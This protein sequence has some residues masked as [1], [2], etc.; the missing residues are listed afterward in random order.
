MRLHD[1]LYDIIDESCSVPQIQNVFA[2]VKKAIESHARFDLQFCLAQPGCE[3]L[4]AEHMR[5]IIQGIVKA[6]YA[7][8]NDQDYCIFF[9]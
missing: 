7:C 6:G 5:R 8:E 1:L 9:K 4:D 3:F 2:A